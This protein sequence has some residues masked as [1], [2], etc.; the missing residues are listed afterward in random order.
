[1]C[2]DIVLV[3]RVVSAQKAL[4]RCRPYF[5]FLFFCQFL[6]GVVIMSLGPTPEQEHG[7]EHMLMAIYEGTLH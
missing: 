6:E 2:I 1:M 4:S 5:R 3:V 7:R